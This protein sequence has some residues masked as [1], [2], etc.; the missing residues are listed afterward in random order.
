MKR[1]AILIGLALI[2]FSFGPVSAGCVDLGR[3]TSWYVQ[4]GQTIIFY[5]GMRPIGKV[6]VA[7][8]TINPNSQIRLARNYT[9]DSDRII[10]DGESCAIMTVTSAA[11]SSF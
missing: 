4:G 1:V 8:C 2:F 3:A 7:Y 9:C 11:S 6:D 10:I 5:A